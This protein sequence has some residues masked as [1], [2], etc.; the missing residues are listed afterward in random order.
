[1]L[2]GAARRARAGESSSVNRDHPRPQPRAHPIGRSGLGVRRAKN[3]QHGAPGLGV[4]D[5]AW[6]PHDPGPTS[7]S[8]AIHDTTV[9]RLVPQSPAVFTGKGGNLGGPCSRSKARLKEGPVRGLGGQI[10][11][12]SEAGLGVHRPCRL[13]LIPP[14]AQSRH[15]A[16]PHHA[17]PQAAA[18]APGIK[19][20]WANLAEAPL[21]SSRL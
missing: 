10:R 5:G 1:M 8:F 20:R 21:A 18:C 9:L 7:P 17:S 14:P 6:S 2:G 19:G 16:P 3:P 12:A 4:R 13:P 11:G 15:G